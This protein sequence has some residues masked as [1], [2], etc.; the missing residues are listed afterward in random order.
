MQ[1]SLGGM[2]VQESHFLAKT[3]S[4]LQ[5]LTH[6][7]QQRRCA[8]QRSMRIGRKP[9]GLQGQFFIPEATGSHRR[10]FKESSWTL[11]ASGRKTSHCT[12]GLTFKA[13]VVL[14]IEPRVPVPGKCNATGLYHHFGAS[15]AQETW[16]AQESQCIVETLCQASIS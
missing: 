3:A 14:R 15:G 16:G 13:S 4:C 7:D 8:L 10:I 2:A 9:P 11:C 12:K 5:K 1:D 6:S